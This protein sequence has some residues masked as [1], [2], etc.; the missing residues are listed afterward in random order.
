MLK[1][2]RPANYSMAIMC[3]CL[4][5][6]TINLH[7]L[8]WYYSIARCVKIKYAD[9]T[10]SI[11]NSKTRIC[12]NYLQTNNVEYK[13]CVLNLFYA[14]VVWYNFQKM[15]RKDLDVFWINSTNKLS[16]KLNNL[17]TYICR[18][19]LKWRTL[20]TVYLPELSMLSTDQIH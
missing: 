6:A 20:L 1:S 18:Y 13:K 11:S 2:R 10:S 12:R 19:A 8:T 7:K 15:K 9:T 4:S 3:Q 5:Y 16:T 14:K 17:L